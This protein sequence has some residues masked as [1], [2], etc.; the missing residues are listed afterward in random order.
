MSTNGTVGFM[1]ESGGRGTLSL[2]WTCLST[3]FIC[4]WVIFHINIPAP[5]NSSLVRS[6]RQTGFMIYGAFIPE[7]IVTIAYTQRQNAER[8]SVDVRN[9]QRTFYL[10][11]PQITSTE[12][13]LNSRRH[14]IKTFRS[15]SIENW[16]SA[17]SFYCVMGGFTINPP[18]STKSFP[19][20]SEQLLWLLKRGCVEMPSISLQELKDKSKADSLL[21]CIAIFQALWFVI[22][23]IGRSCQSLPT[24]TLE[25]TTVSYVLCMIPCQVLWWSKP[26]SVAVGTPLKVIFWPEGTRESLKDLSFK[27]GH[28]FWVKRELIE[29][30]RM[31]NDVELQK[32][33]KDGWHNIPNWAPMMLIG[34]IFG[35]TQCIAW[36]FYFPTSYEMLL[37]RMSSGFIVGLAFI[38][39][40]GNWMYKRRFIGL[41][42]HIV[43]GHLFYSV[44]LVARTI[45]MV[46]V[47]IGLRRVPQGVY[48]TVDWSKYIP[49]IA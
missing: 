48:D 36:R 38:G 12:V 20:N 40:L 1:P 43:L 39:T 31:L 46:E 29:F 30:P 4:L 5:K 15:I 47:F 24:T 8:L 41:K 42:T 16:T 7:Y 6:L 26:Y 49:M 18:N 22:Q 14:A 45:L 2:I 3:W 17:H 34:L 35:G 9:L 28:S 10:P 32:D 27:V 19:V 37:W 11:I 21:K 23:C 33:W 44:Y 25:I 13:E